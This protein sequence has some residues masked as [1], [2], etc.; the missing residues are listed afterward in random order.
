M[1]RIESRTTDELLAGMIENSR[2]EKAVVTFSGIKPG[3]PEAKPIVIA[4]G[5]GSA[6]ERLLN[7]IS[8]YAEI[9]EEAG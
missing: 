5:V 2:H 4:V 6:A 8:L 1:P 9:I 3:L 7:L